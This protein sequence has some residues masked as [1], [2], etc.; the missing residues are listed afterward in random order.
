MRRPHRS[1]RHVLPTAAVLTAALLATA[2]CGSGSGSGHSSTAASGGAFPATV[3]THG[4]PVTLDK[5]PTSIISLSPTT[6]EMLYAIGAGKQVR[7]VD[8]QSTYP[9]AA[10]RTKLSGFKPNV[11]AIAGYRP[12]L[13]IVSY[14]TADVVNG[15]KK[16]KIPVYMAD[17]AQKLTDSYREIT[18]LGKLTGHRSQAAKTVSGMRDGIAKAE[19]GLP[20]RKKPLSYYYELDPELHSLTSKTFVGAL[21]A[22]MGLTNVAD[23][24]DSDGSGYPALSKEYLL[25]ANPDLVLLADTK[26]CGQS[27]AT[28]VKRPGWNTMTAV[29]TKR[30]YTLDDDVASRWGPRIV[31]LVQTVAKAVKSVPAS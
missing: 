19:Q 22:P 9:A 2:G 10:P 4:G 16:L 20:K 8:D 6:T 14:D 29:R 7:A 30:V 27:T 1:F 12:D 3:Q 13:V 28:A 26:C 18:D 31:Q 17:A 21:L 24:A 11:E 23:K 15:L 5:R 25:K